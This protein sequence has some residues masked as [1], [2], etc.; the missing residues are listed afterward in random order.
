[1]NDHPA[2]PAP[3]PTPAT[4]RAG[5]AGL[6]I[7]I[8]EDQYMIA[9]ELRRVLEAAGLEIVGPFSTL[10]AALAAVDDDIDLALLDVNLHGLAVFEVAD[11][12][13]GRG[14]PY[15][16]ATAYEAGALPVPYRSIARVEKP[17]EPQAL[18]DTLRRL[19]AGRVI[20]TP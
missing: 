14:V 2:I 4:A 15:A 18:L 5:L 8:A 12:L 10:R 3:A 1:M 7:L 20:R 13:A 6:R 11:A 19:A 17:V 16:F 9:S